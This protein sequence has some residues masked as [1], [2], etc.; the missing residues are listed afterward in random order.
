MRRRTWNGARGLVSG[1][2]TGPFRFA[3]PATNGLPSPLFSVAMTAGPFAITSA[4]TVGTF[5]SAIGAATNCVLWYPDFTTAWPSGAAT[6]AAT[7]RYQIMTLTPT[8]GSV[9]ISGGIRLSDGGVDSPMVSGTS[10]TGIVTSGSPTLSS[11]GAVT[12]P[13]GTYMT[14]GATN[15]GVYATLSTA[16]TSSTASGTHLSC[17]TFTATSAATIVGFADLAGMT[18]GSYDAQ[19]QQL[20]R[21]SHGYNIVMRFAHEMSGFWYPWGVGAGGSGFTAAQFVSMWN[22]VRSVWRAQETGS[23]Y[24]HIPW[25][26][27]PNTTGNLANT[28]A[29]AGILTTGSGTGSQNPIYAPSSPGAAGTGS[30]FYPGDSACEFVG[31]DGY[32]YPDTFAGN[33]PSFSRIFSADLTWLGSSIT[34]TKPILICEVGVDATIGSTARASW[35]EAMFTYLVSN[36]RIQGLNYFDH[37]AGSGGT[38]YEL[39]NDPTACSGFLSG[40]ESWV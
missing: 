33:D 1:G 37:G 38:G 7:G 8:T 15:Q 35:L 18:S 20:A 13:V 40:L 21:Y 3:A 6:I 14:I 34:T 26:W 12:Q 9:A 39:E 17:S 29:A 24:S 30:C 32:S 19:I 25:I 31:L 36:P 22:H 4:P 28:A 27:G 16:L 5:E 11:D 2:T 23:G 10:Y